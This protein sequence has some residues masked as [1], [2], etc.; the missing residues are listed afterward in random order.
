MICPIAAIE[1]DELPDIAPKSAQVT[2]VTAP[3]PPLTRPTIE[4]TILRE[5]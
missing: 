3:N 1:A 4:L 5:L 2:T